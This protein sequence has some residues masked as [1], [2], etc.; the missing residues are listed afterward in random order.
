MSHSKQAVAGD[1]AVLNGGVFFRAF[2]GDVGSELWRVDSDGIELVRDIVPGTDS[3][4][5]YDMYPY[6]DAVYFSARASG[7]RELWV[8]DGTA[9]G[10]HLV[11][12]IHPGENSSYAYSSNLNYFTEFKESSLMDG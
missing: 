2:T 7:D 1:L 12:D 11:A 4:V 5:P 8:S 9:E 6:G 10:T 3:S